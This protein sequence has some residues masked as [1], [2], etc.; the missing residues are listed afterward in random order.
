MAHC[1]TC[2]CHSTFQKHPDTPTLPDAAKVILLGNDPPSSSDISM[3]H[4]CRRSLESF[5]TRINA[6][7]TALSSMQD[8]L[9]IVYKRRQELLRA[10]QKDRDSLDKCHRELLGAV[11]PL[12]RIPLELLQEI[13]LKAVEPDEPRY[14]GFAVFCPDEAPWIVRCVCRKWRMAARCPQLWANLTISHDY[15]SMSVLKDVLAWSGSHPLS[16]HFT[17]YDDDDDD[18]GYGRSI[19]QILVSHSKRWYRASFEIVATYFLDALSLSKGKL[20]MLAELIF[21]NWGYPQ[22]MTLSIQT[23]HF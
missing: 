2:C 17:C 3:L 20:P 12:R 11:S 21:W 15:G 22:Y 19:L 5:I 13:F 6:E 7:I 23:I 16:F 1:A 9:K 10:L 14:S 8:E 18:D 4:E